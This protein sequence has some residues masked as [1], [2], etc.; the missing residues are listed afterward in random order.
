MP[1]KRFEGKEVLSTGIEIPNAAGGLRA[2][3]QI[4]PQEFH[5]GERRWVVLEVVTEK[6]RHDPIGT[7]PALSRVHI[8]KADAA[9]FVPREVVQPHLDAQAARLA[10]ADEE[11]EA[12]EEAERLAAEEAAG[13]QSIPGVREAAPRKRRRSGSGP[14]PIDASDLTGALGNPDD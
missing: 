10:E 8:M 7:T 14:R 12:A 9:T 1:L 6:I 5:H 2:A 4:D 11:R 3:L 13:V